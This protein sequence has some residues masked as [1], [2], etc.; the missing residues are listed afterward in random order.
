MPWAAA[1]IGGS[2]ALNAGSSILGGSIAASAANKAANTQ[3]EMYQQTAANEQPY[4]N[5]GASTA[6]QTGAFAQW[7]GSQY[8]TSPYLTAATNAMP[9]S[10]GAMTEAELQQTPGYQFTLGQGL[11]STQAANAARGLGVSGAA[12]K[13][14]ATYATG[15]ADSTYANRFNEAQQT[16]SDWLS[17]NTA[18]Q[19]NLSNQYSMLSDATKIGSNAAAQL[20]QS[21]TTLA[22]AAG[23]YQN[24]AGQDIAAGLKGASNALSQGVQNYIGYNNYT[25]NQGTGGYQNLGGASGAGTSD[26]AQSNW[27]NYL[28]GH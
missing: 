1:A 6:D 10:S 20:A 14:A 27:N 5:L 16:F 9:A 26:A 8:G 28:A 13:G 3:K 7:Q 24:Q 19:G 12:L 17:Q 15:L 4:M 25:S 22:G 2:A 21:G 23:N 11:K 18:Y